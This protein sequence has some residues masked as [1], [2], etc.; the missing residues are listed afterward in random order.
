VSAN[1]SHTENAFPFSF[2]ASD[3]AVFGKKRVEAFAN[4]Q[5]EL[6]DE[7]QA[8]NRYWMDRFQSDRLTGAHTIP[9]AMVIS[10]HWTS[11]YL[12]MLAE[13]RKHMADDTRKFMEIGARMFSNG[14]SAG[15]P[16]PA[17]TASA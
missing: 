16:A 14:L 17:A 11:S 7:F 6:L 2:Q 9:D 4:A 8:A 15:P 3:F 13:D 5:T 1:Q 10:R 12:Q